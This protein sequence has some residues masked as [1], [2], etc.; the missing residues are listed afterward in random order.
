MAKQILK[1]ILAWLRQSYR[2]EKRYMRGTRQ[3]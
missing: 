2:P 3:V 1:T